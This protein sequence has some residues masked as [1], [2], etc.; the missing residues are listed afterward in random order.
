MNLE[1]YYTLFIELE[2]V[3]KP[4]V[5]LSTKDYG[6]AAIGLEKEIEG[7]NLRKGVIVEVKKRI[8]KEVVLG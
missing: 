6:I 3:E 1:T 8:I 5:V 2:G 7:G 4:H